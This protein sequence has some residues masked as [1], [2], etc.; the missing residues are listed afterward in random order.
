MRGGGG[1][2]LNG[3]PVDEETLTWEYDAGGGLTLDKI[4]AGGVEGEDEADSD[5]AA[6]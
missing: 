5:V 6:I 3:V 2:V 1:L 4:A